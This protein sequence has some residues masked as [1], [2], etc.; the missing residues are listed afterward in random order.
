MILYLS[1]ATCFVKISS[2]CLFLAL[3]FCADE[4]G[5]GDLCPFPREVIEVEA[6]FRLGSEIRVDGSGLGNK[7]PRHC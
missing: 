5:F 7:K 2:L 3:I 1:V 4:F 6:D